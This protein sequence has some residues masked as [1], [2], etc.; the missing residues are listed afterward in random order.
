MGV[1]TSGGV[2]SIVFS[3]CS[4]LD[5]NK[6]QYDIVYED[7]SERSIPETLINMGTGHFCI[8][9]IKHP[10]KYI[11]SLCKIIRNG[12]Y[13]IIHCNISTLSV[14][15]LIAAVICGVKVR[16][17]HNHSTSSKLETKR[18]IAKKLLR[19]ISRSLSNKWCACSEKAGRW[20][21]GDKAFESGKVKVI[22]NCTDTGKYAYSEEKREE[23][24]KEFNFENKTVVGHIGRFVTVKNHRFL[25]DIF[26]AYRKINA[27]SVLLLVGEGPMEQEIRE[28]AVQKGLSD[29]MIFAG[30]RNDADKIYSAMDVFLL[31]SLYEGL[32]VVSVEAAAAGLPQI[33]SNEVTKET[34]FNES[35]R[36]LPIDN[37][38]E[39]ADEINNMTHFDRKKLSDSF[40][41]SD[42]GIKKCVKELENYYDECLK[43]L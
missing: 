29:T 15:P 30:V 39:W 7:T 33:L 3:Y 13:R 36:Y 38:S 12:K 25:I 8:P 22:K 41:D 6:Y 43:S 2:E 20:M 21:Y 31:P 42:Y 9:S 28:Y 27:D 10:L 18:N 26:E 1:I 17:I 4:A 16:I 14:F 40:S 23:I 19:P 24:R 35:V 5:K 11:R 34:H 32:P 37:A